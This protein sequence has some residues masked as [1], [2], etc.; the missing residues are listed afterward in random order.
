[1]IE[2]VFRGG[3]IRTIKS[4]G[5]QYSRWTG[6]NLHEIS[7]STIVGLLST[8]HSS[9]GHRSDD[10]WAN[11]ETLTKGLGPITNLTNMDRNIGIFGS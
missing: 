9:L 11:P 7:T 6:F 10:L 2:Y 3:T 1:M 5:G 4:D 8:L